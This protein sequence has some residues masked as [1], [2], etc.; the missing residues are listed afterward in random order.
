MSEQTAQEYQEMLDNVINEM[1]SRV[2]PYVKQLKFDRHFEFYWKYRK[3]WDKFK[4]DY[5]HARCVL[6]ERFMQ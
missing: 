2:K 1:M 4:E 5:S 3:A 6:L